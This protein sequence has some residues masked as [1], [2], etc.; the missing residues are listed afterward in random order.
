MNFAIIPTTGTR[1]SLVDAIAAIRPQVDEVLVI[2]NG[3]VREHLWSFGPAR[4]R[5]IVTIPYD[6]GKPFNLSEA[7]NLGLRTANLMARAEGAQEWFGAVLNDDAIVPPGW[8]EAVSLTMDR[9]GAAAG[10]S[11]ATIGE[12]FHVQSGPVD[13]FTTMR[14]WA[15]I[16][17][18]SKQLYADERFHWWFGDNDLGWRA[19]DAGGMVMIRGYEVKNLYPNGSFTAELHIR[20]GLDAAEFEKKW[21]RAAW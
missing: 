5:H 17:R 13:L 9:L 15:F 2:H 10:C 7:W 19:A 6:D 4:E 8:F 12:V 16:L 1:A 20:A 21:G 18:G 3:P 14:G 11:G